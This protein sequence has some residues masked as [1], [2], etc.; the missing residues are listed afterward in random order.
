[1]MAKSNSKPASGS[2]RPDRSEIG[3]EFDAAHISGD[4]EQ[5]L[6]HE[7]QS[8]DSCFRVDWRGEF[9][10][11]FDD[12]NRRFSCSPVVPVAPKPGYRLTVCRDEKTASSRTFDRV[13]VLKAMD[14]V[15]RGADEE[16]R[17]ISESLRSDTISVMVKAVSWWKAM[18]KKFPKEMK[19]TYVK[20][21]DITVS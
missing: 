13:E 19:K 20:F 2:K 18:D 8:T 7:E 4:E 9:E 21:K 15:L 6:T 3:I 14:R 5:I 10:E 12:V 1:M 16:M 11:M 17:V